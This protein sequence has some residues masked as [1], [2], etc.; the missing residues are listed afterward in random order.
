MAA[1]CE[2]LSGVGAPSNS[3][4]P[5]PNGQPY[6]V[7]TTGGNL[8]WWSGVAW[9]QVA[10]SALDIN[11]E[12]A[13]RRVQLTNDEFATLPVASGTDFG[14]V[15]IG[16]GFTLLPD[17][18]LTVASSGPA[19]TTV[20]FTVTGDNLRVTVNGVSADVPLSSLGLGSGSGP[21]TPAIITSIFTGVACVDLTA[22]LARCGTTA[23]IVA[24]VVASGNVVAPP[25]AGSAAGNYFLTINPAGGYS[26]SLQQTVISPEAF[27]FKLAGSWNNGSGGTFAYGLALSGPKT[28]S[29]IASDTGAVIASATSIVAFTTNGT[30]FYRITLAETSSTATP[31]LLRDDS[32]GLFIS[33][34]NPGTAATPPFI[35]NDTSSN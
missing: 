35:G 18:T 20:A 10:P 7:D 19:G 1:C 25:A 4:P 11:Y 31:R 15:K 32:T 29:I 5:A 24:A 26:W 28:Y 6:Y 33:T 2:P 9:K 14:L 21:I 27:T 8:Y 30:S 13:T 22:A 12:P 34:A 23:A 17:G 16:T 3:R